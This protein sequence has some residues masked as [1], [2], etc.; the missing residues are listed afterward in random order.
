MKVALVAIVKQE[1]HLAEWVKW[2]RSLG[3]DEIY[4]ICNDWQP[5]EDL[6]VRLLI[7]SGKGLQLKVYNAWISSFGRPYDF[8]AFLD[9]DEYLYLSDHNS[10]KDILSDRSIGINWV[11]F[12]SE[13]N[14]HNTGVVSRF[15]YRQQGVDKHIKSIVKLGEGVKMLDPHH[16][17]THTYSLEGQ[18]LKGPFYRSGSDA[19][20]FIA[21]YYTQDF[22]Y[23]KKKCDRGRADTGDRFNHSYSEWEEYNKICNQVWDSRLAERFKQ[24]K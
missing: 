5:A 3:F 15:Q 10:V 6:S 11:F 16:S 2:H 24:L 21:H 1:A 23:F 22:E 9:A 17:N 14:G 4:L 8:V 13:E 20:A 12:G 19:N 7:A 18:L